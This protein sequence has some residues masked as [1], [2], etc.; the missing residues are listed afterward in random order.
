MKFVVLS[1][2]LGENWKWSKYLI[3]EDFLGKLQNL[4]NEIIAIKTD[5][6]KDFEIILSY[7][8]II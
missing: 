2:I 4:I 8:H 3:I 1:F 6:Y 7:V 5:R